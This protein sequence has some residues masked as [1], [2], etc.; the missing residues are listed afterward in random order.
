MA[1]HGCVTF[2]ACNPEASLALVFGCHP[3]PPA[4]SDIRRDRTIWSDVLLQKTQ[5]LQQLMPNALN[6]EAVQC[7]RTLF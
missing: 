1:P 2:C 5:L 6:R 7:G 3:R 4:W